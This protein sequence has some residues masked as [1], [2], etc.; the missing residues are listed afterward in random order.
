MIR[1]FNRKSPVIFNILPVL[2]EGKAMEKYDLF[3]VTIASLK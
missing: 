2:P 1:K 3:L